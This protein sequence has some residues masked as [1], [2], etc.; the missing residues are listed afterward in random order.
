MATLW[1]PWGYD[2]DEDALLAIPDIITPADISVASGGRIAATDA[3]LDPVCHA[4]SAAIRNFC[5][6]HVAPNLHCVLSTSVDDR[7]IYLP[8]KHVR[9]VDSVTAGDDT[10]AATD[11]EWRRDGMIRLR[12]RPTHRG[13]WGAYTIEYDAGVDLSSSTLVG[14]AAQIALNDLVASPGVRSESVGQVSLSYNQ[15]VDGVAGGITLMQRDRE[16]L[17]GYKLPTRPR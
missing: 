11:Y 9:A 3:R 1:T 2:V 14:V 15:G 16:L 5:G 8:A 4:V 13:V 6:W 10:L 12:H 17:V 7:V